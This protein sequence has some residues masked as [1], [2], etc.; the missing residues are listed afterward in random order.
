MS[1]LTISEMRP[2]PCGDLRQAVPHQVAR[3]EPAGDGRQPVGADVGRQRLERRWRRSRASP[4][5]APARPRPPPRARRATPRPPPRGRRASIASRSAGRAALAR[6][7]LRSASIV[8]ANDGVASGCASARSAS[9]SSV[10]RVRELRGAALHG[11]GRVVELVRHAGGQR[12]ELGHLLGLP[13]HRLGRAPARE[14]GEEHD[15]RRGRAALHQLV[16]QRLVDR[17]AACT[18]RGRGR[19]RCAA[20]SRAAPSRRSRRPTRAPR[21]APRGPPRS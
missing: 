15:A 11:G 20:P 12:A 21:A 6:T 8:L 18:P 2:A 7:L 19:S 17:R 9:S 3:G 4:A 13:Q 10:E 5:W 16:E 14:H 1:A